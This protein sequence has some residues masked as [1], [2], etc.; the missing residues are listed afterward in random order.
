MKGRKGGSKPSHPIICLCPTAA[1]DGCF[2]TT[3]KISSSPLELLRFILARRLFPK[4][5]ISNGERKG[6]RVS[7]DACEKEKLQRSIRP[8]HAQQGSH[9]RLQAAAI[10]LKTHAG[11]AQIA[12]D[13]FLQ[14]SARFELCFRLSLNL[15]LKPQADF[16]G[17]VRRSAWP[18][19]LCSFG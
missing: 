10:A 12:R 7:N 4:C 17:A 15:E 13:H 8:Q 16:S 3:W 1:P 9:A 19:M 5:I 2:L 6:V 18:S 11:R 14:D